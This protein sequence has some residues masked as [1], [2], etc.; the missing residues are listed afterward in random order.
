MKIATRLSSITRRITPSF[1]VEGWDKGQ[2]TLSIDMMFCRVG[3]RRA[4][5][6]HAPTAV[7]FKLGAPF[8][9]WRLV[10][11]YLWHPYSARLRMQLFLPLLSVF[12]SAGTAAATTGVPSTLWRPVYRVGPRRLLVPSGWMTR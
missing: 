7:L 10:C 11:G 12:W 4:F 9:R 1:I 2:C 6:K 8:M 3:N 5:A